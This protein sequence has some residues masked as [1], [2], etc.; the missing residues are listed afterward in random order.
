MIAD[1]LIGLR[2]RATL[3]DPA[4]WYEANARCGRDALGWSVANGAFALALV[5]CR[6][7]LGIDVCAGLALGGSVAG[8]RCVGAR[9]WWTA[10]RLP[11]QRARGEWPPT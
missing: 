5:P 6:G 10:N 3:A 7:R 2:T 1:V 4:V 9:G 11:A 8:L